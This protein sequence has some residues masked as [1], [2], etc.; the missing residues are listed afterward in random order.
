M[1]DD[2]DSKTLFVIFM[3][4]AAEDEE[5]FERWNSEE[6]IPERLTVPGF[7]RASRYR[8]EPNG[9]HRAP[10][11]ATAG[12]KHMTVYELAH[13]DVLNSPEYS[14]GTLSEWTRRMAPRLK[15]GV[16]EVYVRT[17]TMAAN[18]VTS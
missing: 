5:E 6:H 2:F 9:R 18:E 13:P 17:S 14:G 1:T 8:V 3:D 10:H 12:P 15:V 16:R 4:V 7:L 11:E